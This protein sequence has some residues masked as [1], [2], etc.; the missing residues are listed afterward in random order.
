MNEGEW[1]PKNQRNTKVR[2]TLKAVKVDLIVNAFLSVYFN[3][4]CGA[5]SSLSFDPA[6]CLA[7]KTLDFLRR[8]CSVQS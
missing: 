7:L 6:V 2:R 4:H 8:L 5:V 1:S 3:L